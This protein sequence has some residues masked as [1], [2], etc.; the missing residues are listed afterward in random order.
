MLIANVSSPKLTTTEAAQA[1]GVK[2]DT[3]RKWRWRG[4]GPGFI[5][6]GHTV[7]YDLAEVAAY[8]AAHRV[9][10]GVH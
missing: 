9:Q 7:R 1:L 3:L 5:R 10:P 8:I 2:P 4:R 6:V